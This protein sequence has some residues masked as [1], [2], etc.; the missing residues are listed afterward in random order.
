MQPSR[1]RLQCT[2]TVADLATDVLEAGVWGGE[3]TIGGQADSWAARHLAGRCHQPSA[4]A[5]CSEAG[6]GLASAVRGAAQAACDCA[7][8][9]TGGLWRARPPYA[10]T[11]S[12]WPASR[13][14]GTGKTNPPAPTN[15]KL[16]IDLGRAEDPQLTCPEKLGGTSALRLRSQPLKLLLSASCLHCCNLH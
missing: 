14:C 5:G 2:Q 8:P 11:S 13:P 10:C 12:R 1:P 3:S 7:T 9:A 15:Q 4:D 6:E 16:S